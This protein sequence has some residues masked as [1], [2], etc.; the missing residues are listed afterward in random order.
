MNYCSLTHLIEIDFASKRACRRI[1]L[2]WTLLN[3]MMPNNYA[4]NIFI[5][6]DRLAYHRRSVGLFPGFFFFHSQFVFCFLFLFFVCVCAHLMNH[7]F[8]DGKKWNWGA[9]KL[10][11]VLMKV[12]YNIKTMR[13]IWNIWCKIFGFIIW[14]R[15]LKFSD[16]LFRSI[17]YLVPIPSSFLS[18]QLAEFPES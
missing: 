10:N 14:Q 2:I 8:W 9:F 12:V 4:Q 11:T 7:F 5:T 3:S 1:T 18:S 15:I 17:K 6:Y 16:W 13:L